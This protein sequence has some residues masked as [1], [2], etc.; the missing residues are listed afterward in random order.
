MR[1]HALMIRDPRSDT[2]NAIG[3]TAHTHTLFANDSYL[4]VMGRDRFAAARRVQLPASYASGR[5]SE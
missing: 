1:L 2:H 3:C 4:I 5:K